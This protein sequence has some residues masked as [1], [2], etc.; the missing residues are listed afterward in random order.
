MFIVD[1]LPSKSMTIGTLL[2]RD[3]DKRRTACFVGSAEVVV[4]MDVV[5]TGVVVGSLH[6]KESQGHPP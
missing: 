1:F 3:V 5:A 4:G 2:D 6:S